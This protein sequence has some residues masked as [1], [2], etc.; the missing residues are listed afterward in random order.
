MPRYPVFGHK[1]SHALRRGL[2]F[3]GKRSLLARDERIT[4]LQRWSYN[5]IRLMIE[6]NEASPLISCNSCNLD[7]CFHLALSYTKYLQFFGACI[8]FSIVVYFYRIILG[9]NFHEHFI[10]SPHLITCNYRA[11]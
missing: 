7:Y 11:V 8:A 6:E 3:K 10:E 9:L 5:R 1:K 2:S 4:G